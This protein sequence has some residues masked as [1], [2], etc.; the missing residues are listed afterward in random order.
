MRRP[1]LVL[2]F[3]LACGLAAAAEAQQ[4]GSAIRGR[5]TDEQKGVLPGASIVIT[6][7]ESGTSRET[8]AGPD[9][10]YLI[11]GLVPGPYRISALLAGF[12]Q[13]TQED[14]VLRI[15]ATIQ[16]DLALQVGGVEEKVTVTGESPQVDLTSAQVGGIINSG[17]L[18][19]LPSG[20][21][22]FTSMIGLLPGVIYNAA[23][24]SSSDSVTINGQNGS[25]VVYQLDGGSNNDDLRG[26]TSG[27]QARPPLEA[28]Q[29]F[30]VVTSQFDAEYGA[31]MAGVVNAVSKQGTNTWHG[32]GFGYFTDDS[33]TAKDILTVQQDAAKPN[34]TKKQ[35]GGTY[36]GPIVR[37]KMHFFASFERQDRKEGRS[38]S[39]ST[40]PDRSFTVAQET[41]SWNY[42][43]RFDHQLNANHAYNVRFLWDHQP[44]YNQV[45]GNG[46]IDTLSIEKDNDW[47]LA[48]THNWVM[49]AT[50]LNTLRVSAVHEK[51]K[52]G[53]PLY[54]ETGDWT[55]AP[56]TLQYLSFID[57]ADTNYADYRNM[58]V[59]AVDDTFSWFI[60]RGGGSHDLKVGSQYQLGEHY[61]EDQRFMNGAFQFPSDRVFNAADPST[62]P[63]RLTIR[64]PQ[65]VKLLSITHS[66]GVFAQ[67]KWQINPHF[68]LS[69]GIRY[70]V[71]I[72][73]LRED[74]NPF[75]SDPDAYPV[76]RNNFQPRVGFAYSPNP[77]SVVRGG[78]GIF[79]E[80]QWIDRFENYSLNRVFTSSFMAQFPTAQA[81]PGPGRGQLPSDPL[82]VAG[83]TLNRSLVN[84]LVP[85]G[86][87]ARNTG[88]VWLDTPDRI[89]P[90][91][92]QASIGYERQIGRQLSVAA[93]YMHIQN[94]NMPLRYNLN[95]ATKQTTG[96][97][98][99][100]T[101]VDLKGVANQLNLSPFASDIFIVEYVAEA[102]YDGLNLVIEKRFSDFWGARLAYALGKGWGNTSGAPTA[103][104]DF[105]VLD[106]RN[107]DQNE[108]PTNVD[109]RH[110]V[111]LSGRIE[112]PRVKG[113]TAG[114]VAR[115]LTGQ[116][117][118]I[119]NSN[120]DV[121]RNNIG[122]DPI[123]PGT[124]S[125]TGLNAITVENAGGRNGAYGP[126]SAQVDLRAGYKLRPAQGRSLEFF[127]EMF[128]VT[129]EPNFANPGG[130]QRLGTFLVPTAL[131][132]GGFPRQFQIG[133]RYGF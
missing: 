115:F 60:A 6:H 86:T 130:D 98:A 43:G 11:Q 122:V 63:E 118:T 105:Q 18:T 127:F 16:V 26:G 2:V 46:T 81:D 85:P 33:M 128:N 77:R 95:P 1:T 126:G 7:Q 83:P 106:Q 82:L 110:A 55:L 14:I 30:Q 124:Y 42:L 5:V 123:A 45:L 54:Q 109:R 23:A 70:D 78:Y 52:R 44:N 97:T 31:A 117:F 114:A 61:R 74:W 88:A 40:R 133:A 67:D 38:R 36:G 129:N 69:L 53:Q 34:T 92:H 28:I 75:F 80:K 20:S 121:N 107:L 73:P 3:A 104:N 17:D 116:P 35:W 113:L 125:G 94:R 108:G 65:M 100:I 132:G 68:T 76:D 59:Y 99:P 131:A 21:R 91:Q 87:L 13:L 24:D 12:R 50:R 112:V 48:A 32:S 58:N 111:T 15:G 90:G 51:P 71:H 96:R 93:D 66:V 10:S 47:S 49:Q 62:Y 41:N 103:T 37:D 8:I 120:V 4:G 72:S 27:A 119:H 89:L 57:Q 102:K 19:N 84:Q 101:R 56:P 39:Y 64:V 29:E 25:G 22:N 79:Y 9:G